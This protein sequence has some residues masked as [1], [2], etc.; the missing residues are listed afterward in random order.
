MV[1]TYLAATHNSPFLQS[2]DAKRL[3]DQT[4]KNYIDNREAMAPIE[5]KRAKR[6]ISKA[7]NF[8]KAFYGV[9]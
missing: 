3:R 2:E 9:K 4:I 1:E 5:Q 6:K 8:C 7:V